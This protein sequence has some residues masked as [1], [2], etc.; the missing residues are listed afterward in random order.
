MTRF[1]LKV[2]LASLTLL[3]A[4]CAINVDKVQLADVEYQNNDRKWNVEDSAAELAYEIDK[5]AINQAKFKNF[6]DDLPLE[7]N[8]LILLNCPKEI[9]LES[10]ASIEELI[11]SIFTLDEINLLV[12]FFRENLAYRALISPQ[13]IQEAVEQF[14]EDEIDKINHIL[15]GTLG[16][17]W[18]TL[19]DS[20]PNKAREVGVLQLE[21]CKDFQGR[22]ST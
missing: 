11:N 18:K 17:K 10:F 12:S 15:G 20:L 9:K 8:A 19:F 14:T 7:H 21:L 22:R 3:I 2:A 5:H 16:E 13:F 1:S 4:S 6:Y